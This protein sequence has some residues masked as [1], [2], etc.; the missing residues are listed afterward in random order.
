LKFNT[1][2]SNSGENEKSCT[3]KEKNGFT[4]E[5]TKEKKRKV[6]NGQEL[7]E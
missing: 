4:T 6:R 3:L 1:L 2:S 7:A 5:K